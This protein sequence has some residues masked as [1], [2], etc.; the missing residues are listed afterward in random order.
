MLASKPCWVSAWPP[1]LE[2]RARS[3]DT[4]RAWL[5]LILALGAPA[6]SAPAQGPPP[7]AA[8]IT[9]SRVYSQDSPHRPRLTLVE[10]EGDPRRGLALAAYVAAGQSAAV[11]LAMLVEARIRDAGLDA[12]VVHPTATGFIAHDLAVAPEDVV[13]FVGVLDRALVAPVTVADGE[14][15]AAHWR[16]APPRQATTAS[17]AA[18]GTC[19]GEL[20]LPPNAEGPAQVPSRLAGWLATLRAGDVAFAVVGTKDYLDA[21]VEA[22]DD[23]RPWVRLGTTGGLVL[24][25]EVAGAQPS[26]TGEQI[27]SVALWGLPAATAAAAAEQLGGADSLLPVRLGAGFPPWSVWRVS[28]NAMRG[29][30]CLR[31]DLRS[32][33]APPSLPAIATSVASTV[34]ELDHTI[35][36]LQPGP[37]ALAKQ[38]LVLEA[39]DQA[40][41]VAA[42]QALSAAEPPGAPAPRRLVHYAGPLATEATTEGASAGLA[43]TGG[44]R[45]PPI[46]VR[47]AVEPGQ[48]Q[49]WMLLGTPC[50]TSA[51]D[52]TS[53]GALA[54]ALHA[55]ASRHE[56]A[57]GVALEPWLTVDGMGMLA[58]AGPAKPDE[59]S[60][61]QAERV[62]E[63]LM[64]ALLD[65][66]PTP[67]FIA[68]SRE[69]LL[70]GMPSGPAPGLALALRQTT[71]NHPSYLEARGTWASLT[72]IS[73]R[74]V[75]LERERFV[76]S[77]LR[78]ASLGNQDE[79]QV[80]AAERRLLSL[81]GSVDPGP[82]ECPPRG[83]VA[84]I[85]GKYVI[86]AS[87]VREPSAIVGVPLPPTPGGP[88]EEA[89]WTEW[90]MNRPGGWLDQ[91]LQRP[92]L[93]STARARALGGSAAAALVIEIHAVD[94][95]HEEAVAQVRGLL[96]RLRAGAANAADVRGA[97]EQMARNEASRQLNP[98]AR[99][100]DVW[101][102]S[103]RQ[104]ATLESLHALHRAA[105][106]AGRE[107]VVMTRAAD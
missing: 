20:V 55:A 57:H 105:F 82:V 63:G 29:G 34:D 18:V 22:V 86:D 47:R 40:A 85:P 75:Q 7:Q 26:P 92:G 79:A 33:G 19:S 78:L 39:P 84:A 81:L 16:A 49:F 38:A 68:A 3:R 15:V 48:G 2:G 30:A 69:L 59:S 52:G 71:S 65:A 41:A 98:R 46:E 54:L 103:T 56:V 101:H 25:G 87:G 76:R 53:A 12:A 91:A 58:H 21:G 28:S 62:A 31:V 102:G 1:E 35:A 80:Q 72:A 5:A 74:S 11:A 13:R 90:L 73:A 70:A 6:C 50:G 36:G 66:G 10:R 17:E 94:D 44:V 4:A 14:R 27:L 64:R 43:M 83:L 100:V 61:A 89:R 106:E 51:E 96:E 99:L 88:S 37:W 9:A 107:V 24:Q 45:L 77:K 42:W 8:A 23:L 67:E 104:A 97:R 93:V 60:V 32:A 95:K